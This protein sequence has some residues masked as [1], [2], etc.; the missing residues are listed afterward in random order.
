MRVSSTRYLT[1]ANA[2]IDFEH[3]GKVLSSLQLTRRR[4]TL[5]V[6]A[7]SLS[8]I[9]ALVPITAAASDVSDANAALTAA[10]QA[11]ASAPTV[12]NAA[13]I[14]SAYTTYNA[15]VAANATTTYT[16]PTTNITKEVVNSEVVI[17]VDNTTISY[18]DPGALGNGE[19]FDVQ[20]GGDLFFGSATTSLA[21]AGANSSIVFDSN[22]TGEGAAI[23]SGGGAVTI[24]DSLF[25]NGSS[26]INGSALSNQD[27]G[28]MTI[29]DSRFFNNDGNLSG[30]VFNDDGSTLTI[31]NSRFDQ[32]SSS[33]EGGAIAS[34]AGGTVIVVDSSFSDNTAGSVGG[35]VDNSAG[36][37]QVAGSSF[38]GNSAAAGGALI[39]TGTST[40]KNSSFS[41]NTAQFGGAL[42]NSGILSITDSSFTG[43]SAN[44]GGGGILA[45]GGTIDL[46]TTSGNVSL[47]S[48]NTSGGEENSIALSSGAGS[49]TTL[50][51]SVESG[52]LLDIRDPMSIFLVMPE[53]L[54]LPNPVLVSGLWV[55]KMNSL[56]LVPGRR[57]LM[58]R[59]GHS[60]F[61]ARVKWPMPRPQMPMLRSG[62]PRSLLPVQIQNLRLVAMQRWWPQGTMPLPLTVPS[63]LPMVQRSA[64]ARQ[65][66]QPLFPTDLPH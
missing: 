56:K 54:P 13:A 30:T 14:S 41:E 7:A 57:P 46:V 31:A 24:V 3:G 64:V 36:T 40:I 37:L 27:G 18:Q 16:T 8:F 29:V 51:T 55:V 21:D 22:A 15:A 26:G 2:E 32:N 10:I 39:N 19:A 66:M 48:G 42:Y 17:Y 58:C 4:L 59:K 5:T 44:L 38:S 12:A 35:A 65:V 63:R 50:D 25:S 60:I 47:F 62:L 20:S 49:T 11:Y 52:G 34:T 43:N 23:H 45:A 6:S 9:L 33:Q 53:R 61:T 28:S 1:S